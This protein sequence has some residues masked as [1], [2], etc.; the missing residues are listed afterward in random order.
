MIIWKLR[1]IFEFKVELSNK[2]NLNKLMF[3][4]PDY[5]NHQWKPSEP[6]CFV[7]ACICFVCS[8]LQHYTALFV[9]VVVVTSSNF[10]VVPPRRGKESGNLRIANEASGAKGKS[11]R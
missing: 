7:Y 10:S 5:E 3:L 9:V 11:R 4:R 1:L 8:F 6:I 2:I